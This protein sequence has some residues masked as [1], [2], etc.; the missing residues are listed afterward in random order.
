MRTVNI[1]NAILD[2]ITSLTNISYQNYSFYPL[3]NT[4]FLLTR[5]KATSIQDIS[6]SK[7]QHVTTVLPGR[8]RWRSTLTQS[9]H[10]R[11]LGL[12]FWPN[13]IKLFY[14]KLLSLLILRSYSS[15]TFL[16]VLFNKS[17]SATCPIWKGLF[18]G[19]I[20]LLLLFPDSSTTNNLL[21]VFESR[22]CV[23]D[24]TN[25][26][27]RVSLTHEGNELKLTFLQ[28]SGF[29]SD[30]TVRHGRQNSAHQVHTSKGSHATYWTGVQ[31]QD[32]T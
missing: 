13:F 2:C 11:F 12:S 7:T 8:I 23:F 32:T 1:F 26:V 16:Q 22:T 19:S 24:A 10:L 21:F 20:L 28:F 17:L 14:S 5:R 30:G 15:A 3:E 9:S 25:F 18:Q 29:F 6:S 27:L 31:M 4:L